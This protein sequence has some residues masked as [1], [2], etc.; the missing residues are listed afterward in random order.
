MASNPAAKEGEA[1]PAKPNYYT[2]NQKKRVLGYKLKMALLEVIER[3][4]LT[5]RVDYKAIAL[6]HQTTA[7]NM[8]QVWVQ[9]KA[10]KIDLGEPGTPEEK[11]IDAR[12]QHEKALLLIRRYKALIIHGF[13]G[14]LF[15]AEDAM[16]NG[17]KDAWKTVSPIAKELKTISDLQTLHE[18]GYMSVLEDLLAQRERSE[19]KLSDAPLNV[20][21]ETKILH[22]NDE[23][24]ALAA[25]RQRYVDPPAEKT[26]AEVS[27]A[28]EVAQNGS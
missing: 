16:T 8:R 28:P 19:K 10:G 24:R 12:M 3:K 11:Q 22:A 17:E 7:G 20:E 27:A 5:D 26:F 21:T 15:A 18:K 25:L 1:K 13:E 4:R 6:R 2:G 9:Y 23:E 14:A